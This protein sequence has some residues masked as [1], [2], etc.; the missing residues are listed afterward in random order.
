[1]RGA[2]ETGCPLA[3]R[4]TSAATPIIDQTVHL[5]DCNVPNDCVAC[6]QTHETGSS[7]YSLCKDKL[8]VHDPLSH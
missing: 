6:Y 3:G 2:D 7:R 5:T 4:N 8:I 1:M